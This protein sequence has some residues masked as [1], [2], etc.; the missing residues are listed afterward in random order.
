MKSGSST[1]VPT[2]SS[3]T[4]IGKR[5]RTESVQ[6]DVDITMAEEE[7]TSRH[8]NPYKHLKSFLRLSAGGA[9]T[10]EAIVGRESEKATLRAYLSSVAREVGMYI[11]GP[12]GTGKTALVTSLGRE[13]SMEGW[14]VVELSFMGLKVGD[15]WKRL[16][17]DLGCGKTE[18]DVKDY[19]ESCQ[20]SV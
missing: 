10:E 6:P 1:S 2:L 14:K 19:L 16:G 12:P 8:S 3:T 9:S 11:S 13:K 18:K 15:V 7:E 17:E 5:T 4:L 20:S